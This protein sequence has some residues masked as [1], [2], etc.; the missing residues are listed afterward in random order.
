MQV[1]K[2]TMLAVLACVGLGLPLMAQESNQ[3]Q[4]KPTGKP[5]PASV[6]KSAPVI[7]KLP[8]GAQPVPAPSVAPHAATV[9]PSDPA[10]SPLGWDQMSHEFGNIPDTAPVTHI[11]K[12]T[13]KT[14]KRVT[15][16]SATGSCGCT[17]PAL[18]K[19]SFEPGEAGEMTVTFNP[20]HRRGP[21]PKQ[22]TV[23]YSEP[24]G[25]PNTLLTI[26]SNV[27]PL[28][29]VEPIKMYLMEVDA[30]AGKSTEITVSGRK[31][32]F[33]VEGVDCA[34]PNLVVSVGNK[35]EVEIDGQ[36]FQQFPISVVVK[37]NAPIGEFQTD[38]VIRTNEETA[39]TQNYIFVADV[40]GELKATPT[41]LSLRAYTPNIPFANVVTL[42]SRTG[43]S[44][45]VTSVDV[46]GRE[47][48]QLVADVEPNNLSG[49][50]AYTIRL[51]GVTPDITGPVTGEIIVRTD[52][53]DNPEIR[54]PFS[55]S[56]RG[57]AAPKM[58]VYP[59]SH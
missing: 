20:M 48:M 27:Q 33:K 19:K 29:I 17:V 5:L 53:P 31:P 14:D 35:R 46:E 36:T 18:A 28:M 43:K 34:N 41:K 39:L 58:P 12:F 7:K 22:I 10:L 13:N 59:T 24:A 37:P 50:P 21:Q 15:I 54:L 32:D 55:T 23:M 3:P 52:M 2:A 6:P 49:K 4:P 56:I 51:N 11:F 40:V 8:P 26:N 44:F 30:K 42:E 1:R 9:Q 57:S 25:T 45:K 47:D 38:L 16:Q